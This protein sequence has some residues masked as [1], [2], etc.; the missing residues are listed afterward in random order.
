M[1]KRIDYC[2]KTITYHGF[3]G[4]VEWSEN[5]KCYFGKILGIRSLVSYEGDTEK[6]LIDDFR[7]AVDDY[8]EMCRAYG[9]EPEIPNI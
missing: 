5:D 1:E 7:G 9:D 8:L 2:T 6:E 4:S 3:T